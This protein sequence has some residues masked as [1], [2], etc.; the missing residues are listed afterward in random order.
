[1]IDKSRGEKIGSVMGSKRNPTG[2]TLTTSI[3]LQNIQLSMLGSVSARNMNYSREDQAS[4]F[5]SFADVS[6]NNEKETFL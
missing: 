1:M 5:K 3:S 2:K 6:F 4:L